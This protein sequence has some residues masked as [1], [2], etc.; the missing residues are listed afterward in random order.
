VL[1]GQVVAELGGN[2]GWQ[3]GY[4]YAGGSLLAV[5]Q[6]GGVNW[7]HE[8]SV[9]KSKR[10]TNISGSI[11]STV[12]LDP[13]GADTNR[14]SNSAF[15][16]QSFT[17]YIRDAN[18]GQDA[19]ARRYSVGGRFSQPD[20]YGGS[21]DFSDP[22][23]LNRYAYTKNDPVNFRDP[24][25]LNLWHF[26][27]NLFRNREGSNSTPDLLFDDSQWWAIGYTDEYRYDHATDPQNPAPTA[28]PSQKLPGCVFD[29]SITTNSLL[30][31][32]QLQAMKNEINRVFATAGQEINFVS[33]SPNYYLNVNAVGANY[34]NNS[35]A[36]GLTPLNGSAV[37]NNGRVFVDRLTTSATRD[38]ASST[39][40]NQNSNA[41][42]IGLGRAGS[43]E[44]SHYLLQ[45]NYD[46]S[47][48][49]GV[50]HSG[51]KGSEWFGK[52]SEGLWKF[53]P[54][55]IKQLNSLCGR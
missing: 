48:I 53:T 3:R 33:S 41:L 1:G 46:S 16:P 17:S 43:H 24:S 47:A 51:F 13:W 6:Q 55:Q 36:V 20:P 14:S 44:I 10:T 34:T 39:A 50:M 22:Q 37:T 25:G 15:Q 9:T 31:S 30:N 2:G 32:K 38:A 45:Q 11:V 54:A 7:V 29:I 12:E 40:F 28:R 21:Y 42:A 27:K 35:G 23:S 52:T 49:T 18:G 5:Q 19:M 8:D 26:I 4:V